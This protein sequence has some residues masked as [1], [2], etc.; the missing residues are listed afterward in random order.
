MKRYI[1][2]AI[3]LILVTVFISSCYDD[4]STLATNSIED[5]K[6]DTTGIGSAIYVGYQED[7]SLSPT[8]SREGN[9]TTN[10]LKYEWALTELPQTDN[11]EY[12]VLSTDKSF[13]HKI[14]RPISSTPYTLKL[15]VT[16]SINGNLQ[17]I[18][19]WK[20]YV[21]SSFTGGLLISDTKDGATSDFTYIKNKTLT[22]N[23]NKDETVYHDILENA[24]GKPYEG[25]MTS[26]CYEVYG[27]TQYSHFNQVWAITNDG[28][29]AR[30][31]CEDLSENGN[32]DSESLITYKPSGFK[33]NKFFRG[34]Q[35]F[36]AYTSN[37]L[38][39]FNNVA[40]NTFGWYDAGAKG[41]T[42]DN[43]VVAT[44]SSS[45]AYYNHSVWLDKVQG[46]FVAYNAGGSGNGYCSTYEANNIFDP[47]DMASKS[48]V[49]GSI[50]EE[51][52]LAT[53]LLKD[54]NSGDY[55]I[56]TLS[57]YVEAQGYWDENYVNWTETSPE[58]PA[59]AKNKF[60][61]PAAGK[62]LLDN[63]V[64]VFFSPKELVMYVATADGV[65]AITYGS[66]STAT[67]STTAKF[68]PA[69]GEKITTAK[70]Y[71]Q[72]EYTNDIS[73]ITGDTPV[74]ASLPWNNKAVVLAT[75]KG[76]YDGKLYVIPITQTG[77]GTI[78]ASKA[79]TY[80]GFGKILDVTSIGY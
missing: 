10:G 75:Q 53:F 78:D 28:Y 5:V 54:D 22:L 50:N 1:L 25:L 71:Q 35:A 79:L 45:S 57:E 16:D 48:A 77:I 52:S 17:Y 58:Q 18:N 55:A 61:I 47:N 30:F 3:V 32:S 56:Y 43:N 9:N 60:I 23:Y 74:Y 33:F 11:T 46:S 70:L 8:I 38:Y 73:T 67:V 26:L 69:S 6:I 36:F 51:G 76:E 14:S 62:T 34:S 21:Q 2:S 44:H 68:T 19:T 12:E 20:V 42:I 39:S 63:A 37:G 24:N 80:T 41:Y 59:A 72:G 4:K 49:A 15:I 64:S 40:Y 29:C 27:Y 13:N 31:N 7:I 65:Y 66:G